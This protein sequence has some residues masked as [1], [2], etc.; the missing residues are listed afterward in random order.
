MLAY[1]F[2]FRFSYV[3]SQVLDARESFSRDELWEGQGL[4]FR[5]LQTSGAAPFYH[6]GVNTETIHPGVPKHSPDIL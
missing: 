2:P 3:E 1:V 6:S 4:L 5:F